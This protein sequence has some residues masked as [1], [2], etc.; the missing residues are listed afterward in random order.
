PP[1]PPEILLAH[2][3]RDRDSR[4]LELGLL[5]FSGT[6]RLRPRRRGREEGGEGEER[7]RADPLRHAAI[8][9]CLS[10]ATHP[11][12]RRARCKFPSAAPPGR[13]S[14]SPFQRLRPPSRPLHPPW[15]PRRTSGSTPP[16]PAGP[17]SPRRSGAF[18]RRPSRRRSRPRSWR[19]SSKKK[20]SARR[21]APRECA[22]A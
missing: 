18:P 3:D 5:G 10:Q 2:V 14:A 1:G 11:P 7:E 9:C 21:A 20:D 13:S 16:P 8:V 22:R 17:R 15:P 19:T 6:A 12:F 4:R